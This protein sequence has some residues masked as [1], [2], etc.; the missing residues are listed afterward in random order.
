LATAQSM[1]DLPPPSEKSMSAAPGTIY[2][3]EQLIQLALESNPRILAARDQAA[4]ASGQLRAAKAVPNP[5]FEYNTGQQRSAT[6]PLTTGNVS[7]WSV[8][9]PL[10][11]PYTVSRALMQLRP[12]IEVRKPRVLPLRWRQLQMSKCV[13]TSYSAERQRSVQRMKTW[14]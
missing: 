10:D 12:I 5:Q 8:T 7:S 9:Q 11:M 6:G 14:T 13:I 3:L 1:S 4:A 2:T